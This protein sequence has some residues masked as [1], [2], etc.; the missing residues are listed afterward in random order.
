MSEIEA[1][2]MAAGPELVQLFVT[3]ARLVMG[4]SAENRRAVM[5]AALAAAEQEI[6]HKEFPG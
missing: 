3:L 5:D 1:F 2:V 4:Q 6:L